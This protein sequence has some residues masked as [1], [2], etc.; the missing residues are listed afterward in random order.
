MGDEGKKKHCFD[1]KSIR[2][3]TG[4]TKNFFFFPSS[5]DILFQSMLSLTKYLKG[6]AFFRNKNAEKEERAE[7]KTAENIDPSSR[8]GNLLSQNF[9]IRRSLCEHQWQHGGRGGKN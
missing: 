8:E 5:T 2:F 9:Y 1:G 4:S 7:A 6:F 3:E